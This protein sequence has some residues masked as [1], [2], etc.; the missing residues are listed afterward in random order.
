MERR[1]G[2]WDREMT[3]GWIRTRVPVGIHARIWSGLLPAPQ[4]PP[5]VSSNQENNCPIKEPEQQGTTTTTTTTC[6]TGW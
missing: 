3:A 4:C 6:T 2:E 1:G 5:V